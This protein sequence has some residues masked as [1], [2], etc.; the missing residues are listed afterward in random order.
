M[1]HDLSA[2]IF[3]TG[4][5]VT[6][7]ILPPNIVHKP[8]KIMVLETSSKSLSVILGNECEWQIV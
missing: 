5:I 6:C 7:S 8:G 3:T 1:V 4:K 2:A